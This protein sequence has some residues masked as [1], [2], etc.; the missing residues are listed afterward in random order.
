LAKKVKAWALANPSKLKTAFNNDK[1]AYKE[2]LALNA[3]ISNATLRKQNTALGN[4]IEVLGY[5]TK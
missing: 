4:T 1:N 2:W 5:T 3:D